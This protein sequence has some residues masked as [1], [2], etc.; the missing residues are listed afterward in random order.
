M[1]QSL[2][3]RLYF[4]SFPVSVGQSCELIFFVH[5]EGTTTNEHHDDECLRPSARGGRPASGGG[6]MRVRQPGIF[7]GEDWGRIGRGGSGW[8]A[9][10]VVAGLSPNCPE[11]LRSGHEYRNVWTSPRPL[12]KTHLTP[13][14]KPLHLVP[15]DPRWRRFRGPDNCEFSGP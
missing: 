14:T 3:C 4:A 13:N 6:T 9:C 7:L 2:S 5:V 10:S 12:P 11:A 1:L 8:T 15:F